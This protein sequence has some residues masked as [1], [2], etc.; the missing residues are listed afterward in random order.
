MNL[1]LIIPILCMSYATH[2]KINTSTLSMSGGK[3]YCLVDGD[4]FNIE[5]ANIKAGQIDKN[6]YVDKPLADDVVAFTIEDDFAWKVTKDC[7]S[8]LDVLDKDIT[9]GHTISCGSGVFSVTYKFIDISGVGTRRFE[10]RGDKLFFE[11]TDGNGRTAN[12]TCVKDSQK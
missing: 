11:E 12:T 8:L 6:M 7:K 1:K 9:P 10:E 4:G 5:I 2:A 3:Y